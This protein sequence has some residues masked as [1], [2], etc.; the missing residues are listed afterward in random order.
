MV[1]AFPWK[2]GP[3][4]VSES[5]LMFPSPVLGVAL[6][7][8]TGGCPEE[9]RCSGETGYPE[10]LFWPERARKPQLRGQSKTRPM[11]IFGD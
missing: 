4:E 2:M 5:I 9:G 11:K 7:G 3:W 1:F 6:L 10:Q 8:T